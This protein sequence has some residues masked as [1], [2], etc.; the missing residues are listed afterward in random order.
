MR[1]GGQTPAGAYHIGITYEMG[2]VLVCGGV[3][4]VGCAE[5]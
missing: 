5:G 1:K 3:D 4:G 2:I